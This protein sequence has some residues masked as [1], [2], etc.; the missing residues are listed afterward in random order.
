[1]I[2]KKYYDPTMLD[3]TEYHGHINQ[4]PE[5]L[6]GYQ[7]LKELYN[8]NIYLALSLSGWEKEKDLPNGYEYY[9][10]SFHYEQI[11]LLWLQRQAKRLNGKL[12]V[13]HDG[14]FYNYNIDN[15]VF[16][17]L[18]TWH[19][20][21]D[22][23]INWHNP[24]IYDKSITKKVSA[25]CNR[26][27]ESKLLIFTAIAEYIGFDNSIITLSDWL[28]KDNIYSPSDSVPIPIRKLS[29]I[30]FEK[31]YGTIYKND[32]FDPEVDNNNKYT[33]NPNIPALQECAIHFTNESFHYSDISHHIGD[34]QHPG[35]YLTEKTLKCLISQTAFVPVGQFDTYGT[36]EQLG[37]EFNYNFDTSFDSIIG[38][39][40]RL[41]AI[42]NLIKQ[43]ANM[44]KEELF[45][46][47]RDS[48]IHNYNHIISGDFYDICEEIN[49]K[50]I[51]KVFNMIE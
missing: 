12:F 6:D 49:K 48:S 16:V 7:W 28:E 20:Q 31:Y 22:K 43:F 41:E 10:L 8:K 25:F 51:E 47:T 13:F 21:L 32:K 4:L 17:T 39:F 37:F 46:G 29:D 19:Y 11:N 27:T 9:I 3:T 40:T 50:S 42:I 33:T 44:S 36:L 38:D 18:Y 1:M 24:V 5:D 23:I 14:N 35:P 26:I 15:V 34:Y 45:E 2:Y 30:F